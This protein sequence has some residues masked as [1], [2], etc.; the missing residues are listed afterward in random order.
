[1]L[2]GEAKPALQQW[3]SDQTAA[4]AVANLDKL[5]RMS[6]DAGF[7][8]LRWYY[9]REPKL[10]AATDIH[11][12]HEGVLNDAAELGTAI[13][14]W[15]QAEVTGTTPY[16]DVDNQPAAFW[17]MVAAWD[18]FAKGK[19]IVPHFTET[20]VW[21]EEKGYAGTADGMWIIDGR[22]TLLDLKTSRGLYTSTWMQLAALWNA[23]EL[24]I[25]QEDGLDAS[26]TGWQDPIQDV[27]VIHIR[28]GDWDSRGTYM[29][30]FCKYVPVPSID[31]HWK[32]FQGLL[33]YAHAMAEA[34]AELKAGTQ[35]G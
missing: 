2:K 18:A 23:P 30:P 33:M 28:P 11:N 21:N 6:E 8:F 5:E 31:A 25:Q 7:K 3:V 15:V 17:E 16:P 10:I 26:V 4:Y 13:H 34:K 1:V 32:G 14:E 29:E 12:Y 9:K 22:Y 35:N 20:T 19:E 24:L 27:A